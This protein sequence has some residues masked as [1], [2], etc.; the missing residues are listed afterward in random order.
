VLKKASWAAMAA[1]T[2]VSSSWATEGAKEPAPA[3]DAAKEAP[4]PPPE[5]RSQRTQHELPLGGQVLKYTATVGWLILVDDKPDEDGKSGEPKPIARFGYTTYTLD[6]VKDLS[7]RPVTFAFNG[8]PGSASIWLHMGVL[9]PRR[10]DA[11]D[12]SYAP[13]PPARVV[14]NEYSI[15]DATDLVMIDPV[16]TGF[17][18]PVGDAKGEDFWGVD[19]D[20]ES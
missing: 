11:G 13:P 10:E 16:G 5:P 1:L 8:G 15:L 19:Q 9:G 4:A 17:S 12:A 7:R 20:I 2:L 3:A 14:D 18:K 6:G